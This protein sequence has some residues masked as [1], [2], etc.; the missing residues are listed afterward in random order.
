MSTENVITLDAVLANTQ[1]NGQPVK[2]PRLRLRVANGPHV[3]FQKLFTGPEFKEFLLDG[4][5]K[6]AD[7]EDASVGTRVA[8]RAPRGLSQVEMRKRREENRI[9][10][11]PSLQQPKAVE[12]PPACSSCGATTGELKR[13]GD[14]AELFCTTCLGGVATALPD[15]EPQAPDPTPAPEPTKEPVV[16]KKPKV[17]EKK[18]KAPAKKK[19]KPAAKSK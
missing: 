6:L 9:A 16:E 18:P 13:V 17:V 15:G 5:N 10:S 1:E 11:L 7:L 14:D 2:R 19:D 3:A 8:P 4:L 12:P